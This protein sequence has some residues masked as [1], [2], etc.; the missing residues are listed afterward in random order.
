MTFCTISVRDIDIDIDRIPF[1]C[2]DKLA[3]NEERK[4]EKERET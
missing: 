3:G 4:E 1:Q 2:G